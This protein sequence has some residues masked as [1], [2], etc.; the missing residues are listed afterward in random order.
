MP[1]NPMPE[2]LSAARRREIEQWFVRRGV[3]QFIDGYGTEQSMDQ[4]A[5]PLITAWIV[6]WTA[7]AAQSYIAHARSSRR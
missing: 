4:R 2:P 7:D 3:P 5:A 6:V 1:A